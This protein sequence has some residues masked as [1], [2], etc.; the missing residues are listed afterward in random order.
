MSNLLKKCSIIIIISFAITAVASRK[1]LSAEKIEAYYI[2]DDEPTN[3]Y[4]H[5]N[6]NNDHIAHSEYEVPTF[7][8]TSKPNQNLQKE[9]AKIWKE[10]CELLAELGI[11]MSDE[12]VDLATI[13]TKRISKRSA[14]SADEEDVGM[15]KTIIVQPIETMPEK[16]IIV[17]P[18][19]TYEEDYKFNMPPPPLFKR[20][21][22][23]PKDTYFK[24][25]DLA[26]QALRI[27]EDLTKAILKNQI[28][29]D[30]LRVLLEQRMANGKEQLKWKPFSL[31]KF[32]SLKLPDFVGRPIGLA[33]GDDVAL[34][35]GLLDDKVKLTGH[36]AKVF[37]DE[38]LSKANLNQDVKFDL[39]DLG[40]KKLDVGDLL[41]IKSFAI[42]DLGK[43]L[44]IV[45]LGKSAGCIK[46][47]WKSVD[48]LG[49][50]DAIDLR[51]IGVVDKVD[52]GKMFVGL[53]GSGG[54]GSL[55]KL[56]DLFKSDQ[57]FSLDK[58]KW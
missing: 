5:Y 17:Q 11:S 47:L 3:E 29:T 26:K 46:D 37:L 12:P 10:V 41:G 15:S 16:R 19:N 20:I 36:K 27:Q 54:V 58:L 33:A 34:S 30:E 23:F 53:G 4:H 25:Y 32:D 49:I 9:G 2:D 22:S 35:F 24:D 8:D 43:Q 45:D 6:N 40:L 18:S 48:D 57:K 38:L 55:D 7:F 21:D 14:R 56:D 51:K 31:V 39:A 1:I 28:K 44:A 42:A 52:F 13:E 50:K